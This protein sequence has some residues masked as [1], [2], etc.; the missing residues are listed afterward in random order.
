M[1]FCCS[2]RES[3]VPFGRTLALQ[4]KKENIIM[5]LWGLRASNTLVGTWDLSTGIRGSGR[6]SVTREAIGGLSRDKRE[7]ARQGKTNKSS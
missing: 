3:L 2:Y 6:A 4:C 7:I 1:D 5:S